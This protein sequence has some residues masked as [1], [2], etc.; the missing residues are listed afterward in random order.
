MKGFLQKWNFM[1]LLRL[2][3]G[4]AILVQGIV[5]KDVITIIIG[6]AFG[7]MAV[8]NAGCCQSGF[9]ALNSQSEKRKN[10]DEELDN[11]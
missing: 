11:K 8:I 1:R 4:I 9:C 6:V 2:V 10:A 7:V 3:F 5:I